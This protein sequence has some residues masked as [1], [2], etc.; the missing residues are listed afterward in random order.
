M[1]SKKE[2]LPVMALNGKDPVDLAALLVM[3]MAE[4]FGNHMSPESAQKN[5]A[6]FMASI[7]TDLFS[8]EGLEY[9]DKGREKYQKMYEAARD[10]AR[11]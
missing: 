5:F 6:N 3:G 4:F 7:A 9:L 8:Q 2:Q 1:V 10:P 11:N